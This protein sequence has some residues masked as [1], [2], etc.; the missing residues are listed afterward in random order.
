MGLHERH[1]FLYSDLEIRQSAKRVRD[2]SYRI[3]VNQNGVHVYN[4]DMYKLANDPYDFYAD[5]KVSDD[6]GHAFYLGVELARAQLAWQLGKRYM[7][8]RELDWGC[9][10]KRR[11]KTESPQRSCVRCGKG[12][13]EKATGRAR[14]A[15]E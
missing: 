11:R 8:E 3:Q 4:R 6:G 7:Q 14:Q 1:P 12:R 5:L 10:V 15:K 9:A 2:P 13:Q